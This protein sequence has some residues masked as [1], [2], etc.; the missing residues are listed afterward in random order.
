LQLLILA[1][2]A[3]SGLPTPNP[4]GDAS[5]VRQHP[6]FK[7]AE[8]FYN[9]AQTRMGILLSRSGVVEAQCFFLAGVYLMSTLRPLEGWKMF[10][11]AL[12]SCQAFYGGVELTAG[13]NDRDKRLREAIYWTCFKSEFEVRLELNV[14]DASVWDLRYPAFFPSPPDELKSNSHTEVVWYY[15]LAEIALRRLA[16]RIL[17]YIY[18]IKPSDTGEARPTDMVETILGFEQ[19]ATDWRTSLPSALSLEKI[20]HPSPGESDLH[21]T[22]RFILEGELLDSYELMYWPFIATA[23]NGT[24]ESGHTVSQDFARKAL[25]VAVQRID[26]NEPGFFYRHHGTWAMLRACTRSGLTLLAASRTPHVK[27]LLPENWRHAVGKVVEM[28]RFWRR[29][30]EDAAD[31]LVLIEQMLRPT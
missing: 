12:A 11:Q 9:A 3:L 21:Q 2:G 23:I 4:P 10:V 6:G 8:A 24:T 31:R 28:L 5:D 16:N 1:L 18:S 13:E 27:H 14:T 7:Q 20:G 30:S 25:N 26:K 22:L 15:F 19:Q 29:E 17:N